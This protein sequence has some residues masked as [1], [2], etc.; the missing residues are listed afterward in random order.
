MTRRTL[1]SSLI[2]NA[3]IKTDI[4]YLIEAETLLE[5]VLR[6]FRRVFGESHPGTKITEDKLSFA[7]RLKARVEKFE[8]REKS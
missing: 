3:R 8:S 5:D 7:R 6:R 1:G 4:S 2:S